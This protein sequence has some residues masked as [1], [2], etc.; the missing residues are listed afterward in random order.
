MV[1]EDHEDCFSNW[2]QCRSMQV[3]HSS[4]VQWQPAVIDRE[5]TCSPENFLVHWQ[6]QIQG[7]GEGIQMFQT[8]WQKDAMN[9][10]RQMGI[11]TLSVSVRPTGMA[12]SV[13]RAQLNEN[14][15]MA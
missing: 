2:R 6:S 14:A 4:D 7:E 8:W 10:E 13:V 11:Y 9:R 12:V 15:G 1:S 3:L 5:E